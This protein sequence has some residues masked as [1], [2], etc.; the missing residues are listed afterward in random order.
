MISR[1]NP[2]LKKLILGAYKNSEFYK[3]LYD[4]HKIDPQ[5][6]N[7]YKDF[8]TLPIIDKS[9]LINNPID[10]FSVCKKSDILSIHSTGGTTDKPKIIFFDKKMWQKNIETV[11]RMCRMA[12]VD[13]NSNVAV[14]F[15][16]G[17]MHS[18]ALVCS[19]SLF[20]LGATLVPL[21][22]GLDDDFIFK[23]IGELN[24]SHIIGI[25]S[26]LF[27]LT[28][29]LRGKGYGLRKFNIKSILTSTEPL[30]SKVRNYLK[31]SWGAELFDFYGAGE[32]GC[33][34]SEC[35]KHN[36]IHLFTDIIFPE[37]LDVKT[38]KPVKPGEIGELVITTLPHEGVRLIRYRL[39]DLVRYEID[40]CSCGWNYPRVWLSGRTRYTIFIYGEN[41]H[42]SEIVEAL[43]RIKEVTD[44]FQLKVHKKKGVY[45]MFFKIEAFKES[46]INKNIL[47]RTKNALENISN[48]FHQLVKAGKVKVQI[49]IVEP[50]S[51]PRTPIGKLKD[52]ILL[53]I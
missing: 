50:N 32:V 19:R 24:V 4:K 30:T 22:T 6:I 49:N 5:R 36:G 20:H 47:T 53:D 38:R 48:V 8:E 52:Q 25:P 1:F 26:Y 28:R 23:M 16:F 3:R 40:K 18:A 42:T 15:S 44:N 21:G 17:E 37:V 27:E 33:M 2:K 11:Q 34:G 7:S 31:N 12:N 46:F 41:I 51:L 39:D 14:M 43:G 13:E 29:R 10:F 45:H 9:D 35:R